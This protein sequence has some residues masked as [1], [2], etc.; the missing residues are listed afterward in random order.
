MR[1]RCSS[2][3]NMGLVMEMFRS[4]VDGIVVGGCPHHSCH[5]MW[6]N[7]LAAKRTVLM[8]ALMREIGLDE[9]RP[10]AEAWHGARIGSRAVQRV[11]AGHDPRHAQAG[12]AGPSPRAGS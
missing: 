3:V 9:R 12:A 10:C 8:Q 2:S 6:G 5:H 11:P 4:G 1:I 7:W